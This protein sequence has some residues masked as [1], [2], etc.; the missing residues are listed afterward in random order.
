MSVLAHPARKREKL[1]YLLQGKYDMRGKLR[2]DTV[3][4]W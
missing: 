4:E 3:A 2:G 1:T